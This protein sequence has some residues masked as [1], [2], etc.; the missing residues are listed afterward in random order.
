MSRCYSAAEVR[1]FPHRPDRS[2]N[3]R[4]LL[5]VLVAFCVIVLLDLALFGWLI[6]RSLSQREIERAL[7]ETRE[8]AEEIAAR[9]ASRAEEEGA[10]LYTVIAIER[11]TRTF[12][13]QVLI[14]RGLVSSVR[15]EA[16]DGT[17]VYEATAE[18]TEPVE[19]PPSLE[20]DGPLELP[21]EEYTEVVTDESRYQVEEPIG[22][23]GVLH[24]GIDEVD[25]QRRIG[26]LRRDLIGQAAVIGALTTALLLAALTLIWLLLRRGS[27]L[28]DQ[29]AEAE[30]MAYV[31][32]LAS[33]LA[34]EIRN[35]L[36]SL[37]LNMQMLEEEL[38]EG[39]G[40]GGAPSG[41]RLLAITRSE[42]GRLERLVTDFLSYARPRPLE[43]ERVPAAELLAQVGELLAGEAESRGIEVVVEDRTGGAEVQVDPGQIRQLLLN[44]A[45][46]ALAAVE[47][48]P[49]PRLVLAAERVAEAGVGTLE[50]VV[51][52][53]GS[54]IPADELERIFDVFYSTRKGGTGL[55]L[56]IVDRI[57]R[58]HDGSVAVESEPGEGTA[59]R[60]TLPEAP[61]HEV[62]AETGGEAVEA[63]GA[64][65]RRPALRAR[66]GR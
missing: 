45:Q 23:F 8:Q 54:G 42:L 5:T 64:L 12:I 17:L 47:H 19:D 53:N 66:P 34:H 32:T 28:E 26:T 55:G 62:E 52:D 16:P 43:L 35:P 24:I 33:G 48:S 18:V 49:R 37:S 3:T 31:G 11:E 40:A 15:V 59:V 56:A 44:L 14:E 2:A 1:A 6:F 4:R 20:F 50:L 46:N 21:G 29:A 7:L 22:T 60:V 30:R 65:S 63:A 41:R 61:P 9:I 38:R 36:N 13:D 51:A 10:D 57:A 27:R 58:R 25:L 39:D